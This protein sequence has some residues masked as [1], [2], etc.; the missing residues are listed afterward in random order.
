MGGFRCCFSAG[1]VIGY[2]CRGLI[3][4]SL[5]FIIVIGGFWR[6]GRDTNTFCVGVG[7]K[8][9][10]S[11][12][13]VIIVVMALLFLFDFV[14][15]EA[16]GCE[17]FVRFHALFL[18]LCGLYMLMTLVPAA[19]IQSVGRCSRLIPEQSIVCSN[20][21]RRNPN[22]SL[23]F[24]NMHLMVYEEN[25][26]RVYT[27]KKEKPSGDI[28]DSAHPARFRYARVEYYWFAFL[29]AYSL[30]PWSCC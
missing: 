29:L 26:K 28:T 8:A 22:S 27:L 25:G 13:V 20:P 9:V 23:T 11:G 5:V 6:L 4:F 30:L 1:G 19:L 3:I 18:L 24:L 21:E 12:P 16:E 17:V 7:N 2:G 10:V 14:P 15:T